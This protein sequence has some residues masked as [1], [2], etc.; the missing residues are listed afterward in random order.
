MIGNQELRLI[1]VI[2]RNGIRIYYI[3]KW[4]TF[5]HM[6]KG[7][8]QQWE[9]IWGGEDAISLINAKKAFSGY[10][11]GDK[12]I[13]SESMTI[14]EKNVEKVILQLTIDRGILHE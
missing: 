2:M 3:Q 7:M 6:E 4:N 1:S 11:V 9:N 10:V 5:F 12:S 8:I 14:S 13:Y